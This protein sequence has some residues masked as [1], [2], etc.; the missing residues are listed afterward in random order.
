MKRLRSFSPESSILKASTATTTT[1]HE[2]PIEC[3]IQRTNIKL[4]LWPSKISDGTRMKANK[5]HTILLYPYLL[6]KYSIRYMGHPNEKVV[7]AS[8]SIFAAFISSG[9]DTAEDETV[10]LNE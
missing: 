8:N 1:V 3:S 2:L 6:S 5:T 10:T 7:Q 4:N 9:K